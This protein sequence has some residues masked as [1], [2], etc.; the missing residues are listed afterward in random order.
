MTEL[1]GVAGPA[2]T[3]PPVITANDA[4]GRGLWGESPTQPGQT[5]PEYSASHNFSYLS[6]DTPSANTNAMHT[7][8]TSQPPGVSDPERTWGLS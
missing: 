8:L 1:P 7:S 4:R 5:F 2:P 3:G 6:V